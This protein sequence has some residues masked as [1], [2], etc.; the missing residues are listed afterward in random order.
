MRQQVIAWERSCHGKSA[1]LAWRPGLSPATASRFRK[2]MTQRRVD[3]RIL[4]CDLGGMNP[5]CLLQ[6]FF[7]CQLERDAEQ[8]GT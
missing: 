3:T 7:C 2:E 6:T 5:C 1:T 8:N 4:E